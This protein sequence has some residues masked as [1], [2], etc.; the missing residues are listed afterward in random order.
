MF[1]RNR[2][3]LAA[4]GLMAVVLLLGLPAPA[5]AAGLRGGEVAASFVARV[6]SWLEGLVP[7]MATPAHRPP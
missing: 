2:R 4:I 1:Q 6:W 7:G 3:F 5:P